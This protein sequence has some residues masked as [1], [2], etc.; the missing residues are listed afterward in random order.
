MKKEIFA[1][2]LLAALLALSLI[3]VRAIKSICADVEE[4]IGDA[5]GYVYAGDWENAERSAEEAI[6]RFESHS[7]YT[8]IVLRHTDIETLTGSFY[9]FLGDIR[10]R[11]AGAAQS[12]A[13][14]V[15]ERLKDIREMES[16]RWGSVF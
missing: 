14:L 6:E 12:S 5:E 3:N 4:L 7:S 1:G 10:C 11:S 8:H 15:R 13:E 16:I 2:A 9:D